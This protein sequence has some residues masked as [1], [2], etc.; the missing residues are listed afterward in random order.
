MDPHDFKAYVHGG[1]LAGM[2][3]DLVELPNTSLLNDAI[4]STTSLTF[5]VRHR[6][7]QK[8][9]QLLH[10]TTGIRIVLKINVKEDFE[11]P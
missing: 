4:L 7:F 5:A 1:I 6:Y 3:L 2:C 8:I 10:C 11:H 9:I